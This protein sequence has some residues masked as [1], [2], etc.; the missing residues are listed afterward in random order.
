MPILRPFIDL[1]KYKLRPKSALFGRHLA[2][3]SVL[4]LTQLFS[5]SVMDMMLIAPKLGQ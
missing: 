2:G 1:Q 4:F 5:L 3:S